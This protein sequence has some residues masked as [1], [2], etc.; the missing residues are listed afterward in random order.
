MTIND[1]EAALTRI[2]AHD[3]G[4]PYPLPIAD[5]TVRTAEFLVH[6]SVHLTYHLGQID[7]HRRILTADPRPVENVSVKELP[8]TAD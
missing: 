2:E 3:L 5:R 4:K 6:L 7:Y 8:R 1:V